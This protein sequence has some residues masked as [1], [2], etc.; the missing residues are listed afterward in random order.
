MSEKRLFGFM[1]IEG[2]LLLILG[3][4]TL[5]LPKLTTLTYNVMV[6]AAFI[7]YGAYKFI[8]PFVNKSFKR[9][10]LCEMLLGIYPVADCTYRRIFYPGK[11]C[12]ICFCGTL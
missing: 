7:A 4:C 12:I 9:P 2:L 11:H 10:F 6:S 1:S 5:I 3:L 8:V